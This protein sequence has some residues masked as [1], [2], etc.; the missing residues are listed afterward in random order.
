[1]CTRCRVDPLLRHLCP[2]FCIRFLY[3]TYAT[4]VLFRRPADAVKVWF[5]TPQAVLD[6][7]LTHTLKD[8]K[9]TA[10]L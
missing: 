7:P 6:A 5:M 10:S 3:H 8:G 4:M 2:R 9:L 1:M